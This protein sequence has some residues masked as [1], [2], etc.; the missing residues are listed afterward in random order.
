VVGHY[1]AGNQAA[2]AGNYDAAIAAYDKGLVLARDEPA[3]LINKAIAL[4]DRGDASFN[5]FTKNKKASSKIAADKDW[6]DAAGASRKAIE[7]LKTATPNANSPASQV[8]EMKLAALSVYAEAMRL[9]GTKVDKSRADAACAAYQEYLA[10]EPDAAARDQ[11]TLD[12]AEIKL[13]SNKPCGS[14]P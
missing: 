6:R 2:D 3:L 11:A 13:A 10:A 7:L 8:N 4:I 12:A 1:E 5:N 14:R 9:V